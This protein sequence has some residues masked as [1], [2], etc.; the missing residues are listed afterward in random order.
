MIADVLI[1]VHL[2]PSLLKALAFTTHGR[3]IAVATV[4]ISENDGGQR[5]A[6]AQLQT[7]ASA[8]L[9]MLFQQIPTLAKRLIAVASTQNN[10]LPSDPLDAA[11]ISAAGLCAETPLLQGYDADACAA[12][13]AGLFGAKPDLGF[14]DFD[15]QANLTAS[16]DWA[17]TLAADILAQQSIVRSL[18]EILASLD[19]KILAKPASRIL[20]HST[21]EN[22]RAMFTGLE[23]GHDLS[24][25]M[26]AIFEGLSFVMRENYLD[27]GSVPQEIRVAGRPAHSIALRVILASVLK[28][29]VRP[30][31]RNHRVATGAAMF[32]AV[33]HNIF[34]TLELCAAQ[35]ASPFLGELT[36]PNESLMNTYERALPIYNEARMTIQPLLTSSFEPTHVA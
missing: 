15:Q 18:D 21:P 11:T 7:N 33:E 26:R 23:I 31:F 35:W 25:L 28:T 2:E 20:H 8:A 29:N 6:R 14:T 1:G 24:D 4:A 12:L 5:L 13:S 16:V 32:A 17:L 10:L 22:L 27:L 19:V 9:S 36:T 30:V 34:D 3:E